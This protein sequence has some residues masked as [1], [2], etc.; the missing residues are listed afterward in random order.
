MSITELGE[1][2]K[3]VNKNPSKSSTNKISAKVHS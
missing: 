2:S 3:I 1:E